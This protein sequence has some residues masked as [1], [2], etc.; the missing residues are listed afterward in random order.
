MTAKS[1]QLT[2]LRENLKD[3]ALTLVP[4]TMDNVDV[5][6]AR[7][8]ETYGDAQKLVNFE[9]KKLESVSTIPNCADNSF[10]ICTRQLLRAW[11]K[12]PNNSLFVEYLTLFFLSFLL[13]E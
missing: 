3:F 9:L 1:D 5:A 6:F 10:T 4:D 7:L 8:N 12:L 11:T 2:K 13:S